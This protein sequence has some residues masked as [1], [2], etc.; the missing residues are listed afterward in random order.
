MTSRAAMTL[1]LTLDG[2]TAGDYLTWMRDPEPPALGSALRSVMVRADPLGD[3]IELELLWHGDPPGLEHA[4]RAAGFPL[5]P[6][7]IAVT[8][9]RVAAPLLRLA[10]A[11]SAA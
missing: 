9:R 10:V 8:P 11:A 1:T 3:S 5:I 6:E 7:V 2:I 4:V